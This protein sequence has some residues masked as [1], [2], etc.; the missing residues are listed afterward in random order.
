MTAQHFSQFVGHRTVARVD[1]Y[2]SSAAH[3][4]LSLVFAAGPSF[5]GGVVVSDLSTSLG[6]N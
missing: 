4:R 3:S 6:K 5:L 1:S 2:G